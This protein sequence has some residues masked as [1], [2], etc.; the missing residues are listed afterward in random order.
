L[1]EKGANLEGGLFSKFM[2]GLTV[3]AYAPFLIPLAP[4]YNRTPPPFSPRIV[5]QLLLYFGL[6]LGIAIMRNDRSDFAMGIVILMLSAVIGWLVSRVK[7]KR[8]Q[9]AYLILGFMFFAVGIPVLSDIAT[10]MVIVRGQYGKQGARADASLTLDALANRDSLLESY[11]PGSDK[12]PNP[13]WDESYYNPSNVFLNRA[14][15]VRFL[16]NT[17]K[18]GRDMNEGQRQQLIDFTIGDA[19]SAFPA[20]FLSAFGVDVDKSVFKS[21]SV[22]D[23]LYY[24][25]TGTGLGSFRAG[26]FV[27]HGYLIFGLFYF[28]ILVGVMICFFVVIDG[29]AYTL[30]LNLSA[31][32]REA[33]GIGSKMVRTTPLIMPY[34]LLTSYDLINPY[35]KGSINHIPQYI[36]RTIPQDLII[37]ALIFYVTGRV[38]F[39]V[40]SLTGKSYVS[41]EASAA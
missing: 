35:V 11:T 12:A 24:L 3:F 21:A 22:S 4:I 29:F 31:E 5:L 30:P 38:A 32:Q 7:I 19:L 8:I 15:N 17:L 33:L 25:Q 40:S 6:I 27:G 16:D 34:A 26:S 13:L 23:F 28:P 1:S 20:P 9:P 41:P 39:Y 14:A 37:Y 10:I 36:V 2:V 18:L